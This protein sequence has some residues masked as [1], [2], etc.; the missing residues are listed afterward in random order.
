MDTLLIGLDL[1]TTTIKAVAYDPATGRVVATAARPPP[2][3][4]PAD[5]RSEHDPEA[6]WQAA[7]GCLRDLSGQTAGRAIAGL[8][9]ASFAEAG[10]PLD[11][12]MQ[13]LYPIIAWYDRRSE[14]Q[15]AWLDAQIGQDALHAITGQRVSPS[16]GVTKWLW[17][18]AHHPDLAA[19]TALWLSA[20]DYLLWRLSGVVATDYTIA[21]RTLLLDQAALDWSPELLALT[22]LTRAQLPRPYASGSFTS[23]L[24]AAAAR[25]TGLPAGTPCFLGG[26]DHV[27]AALAAGAWR[28]GALVDSTGTAQAVLSVLP[29]FYTGSAAA[30]GGFACYHHVAPDAYVLKAGLKLAGGAVE[31][32]ARLL[33]GSPAGADLPYAALEAEAE[34]GIGKANGPLWLPHLIGSGTPEGDRF[35]LAAAVGLRPEHTR[36][37]LFRGLLESL[38]FWLRHNVAAMTALTGQTPNEVILLGGVTRLRLLSQLKADCLNLPVSEPELMEAAATGAALLAGVGAG[39]F[40]DMATACA[41]VQADRRVFTP[42]PARVAHYARLYE[43]YVSLYPSLKPIHHGLGSA[44]TII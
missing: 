25:A 15:A 30:R 21:S 36:G 43:S 27:C 18:R 35:S 13:P 24:A 38:A 42:D 5:D 32:L 17:I 4:H 2:V 12:A 34:M 10:L 19:G 39:V 44:G 7:A 9:I 26:H 14:P 40:P 33:A 22:G 41:S 20:S 37:D 23:G 31:W 8:A 11:A 16:F 1:G 29:G 3:H 6:L 28:P